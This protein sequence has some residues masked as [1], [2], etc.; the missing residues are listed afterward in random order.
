MSERTASS[1]VSLE[2]RK[3]VANILS[4]KTA[5][6][7]MRYIYRVEIAVQQTVMQ[8]CGISQTTCSKNLK[9]LVAVGLVNKEPYG[10]RK[11]YSINKKAW[12]TYGLEYRLWL[13]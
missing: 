8:G 9:R 1:K 13:N 11:M 3:D 5:L 4:N 10:R 12:R 6:A 2:T 7:V